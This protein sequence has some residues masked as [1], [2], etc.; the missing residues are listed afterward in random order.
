MLALQ[1][2]LVGLQAVIHLVK[3]FGDG[4]I[5]DR[6]TLAPEFLRQHPYALT[7]PAKGR[8]RISASRRIHQ[9]V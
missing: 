9:T 3:Q 5:T 1:L 8:F 7:G 2:L 4:L 6:M